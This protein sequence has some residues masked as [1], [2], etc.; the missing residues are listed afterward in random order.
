MEVSASLR[1]CDPTQSLLVPLTAPFSLKGPCTSMLQAPTIPSQT[2][3]KCWFAFPSRL[4]V[5][6]T[7]ARDQPSPKCDRHTH[8][9]VCEVA[10]GDTWKK[11]HLNTQVYRQ[12]C[13]QQ[14]KP[15]TS[16]FLR[17]RLIF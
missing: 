3:A 15:V 8:K 13:N 11:T 14:I 10:S 1:S 12:V 9:A 5:K 2:T 6:F 17:M 4:T 7:C 16:L